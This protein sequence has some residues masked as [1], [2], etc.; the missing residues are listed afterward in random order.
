MDMITTVKCLGAATERS[1][2]F[3]FPQKLIT[4][5]VVQ[6]LHSENNSNTNPGKSNKIYNIINI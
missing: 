3:W 5:A 6:R 2:L 4:L 1:A